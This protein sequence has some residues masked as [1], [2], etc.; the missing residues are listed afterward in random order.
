MTMVF[1]S[2]ALFPCTVTLRF[3]VTLE[4][5]PLDLSCRILDLPLLL[6]FEDGVAYR[7]RN[8]PPLG[9][10]RG[11]DEVLFAGTYT[12]VYWLAELLSWD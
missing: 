5:L 10:H 6:L 7:F 1:A 4:A 3:P 2:A 9:T 12:I 11:K 8:K